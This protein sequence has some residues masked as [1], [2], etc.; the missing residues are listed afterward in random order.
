[1]RAS[2]CRPREADAPMIALVAW[3]ARKRARIGYS[4]VDHVG[5]WSRSLFGTRAM[6]VHFA[7]RT[8]DLASRLDILLSRSAHAAGRASRARTTSPQGRGSAERRPRQWRCRLRPRLRP[9]ART[10]ASSHPSLTGQRPRE[11]HVTRRPVGGSM[12]IARRKAAAACSNWPRTR[13]VD[14]DARDGTHRAGRAGPLRGCGRSPC[15]GGRWRRGSFHTPG[16]LRAACI[17]RRASARRNAAL[18][19]CRKP[20]EQKRMR[21]SAAWASARSVRSPERGS[22]PPRL[23][24]GLGVID[25]AHR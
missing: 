11:L 21:P 24:Q 6:L 22:R 10:K 2:G 5:V 19:P 7:Q 23:A 18:V 9:R 3:I 1:M 20:I 17:E 15:R 16:G 14:G 25:R 4:G 13:G 12:S 8:V